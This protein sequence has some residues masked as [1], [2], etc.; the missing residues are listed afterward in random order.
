MRSYEYV[1]DTLR[2]GAG[3]DDSLDVTFRYHFEVANGKRMKR[4]VGVAKLG[5]AEADGR[6]VI[7]RE[8][9]SVKGRK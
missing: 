3:N 8:S 2:I 5:V 4:G 6:F 9:G 1:A 7:V